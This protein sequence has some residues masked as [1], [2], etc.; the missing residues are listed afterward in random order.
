M[1]LDSF[2]MN[3]VAKYDALDK[4]KMWKLSTGTIGEEI[5]RKCVEEQK[6]EQ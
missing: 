6:Y 2:T 3:I 1:K 5:M 4:E